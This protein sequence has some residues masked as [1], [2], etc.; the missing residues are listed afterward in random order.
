M[1]PFTLSFSVELMKANTA[2]E[3]KHQAR[4]A[5]EKV[6][7]ELLWDITTLRQLNEKGR[8]LSRGHL[9]QPQSARFEFNLQRKLSGIRTHLQ[10]V[11]KGVFRFK[12]TP[13]TH[14]FVLI[15]SSELRDKKPYAVPIQFFPY[16]GLK[17][18]DMRRIVTLLVKEMV[19]NGMKVAGKFVYLNMYM[20]IL[21]LFMYVH[22]YTCLRL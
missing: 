21:C 16:A 12:R 7:F 20:Y 2:Y 19:C 3:E 22:F 6:V 13:A 9:D 8:T 17:E 1:Y 5:P 15:I 14:I 18:V 4:N 11:V 10:E